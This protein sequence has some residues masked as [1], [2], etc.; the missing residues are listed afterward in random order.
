MKAS[1]DYSFLIPYCSQY[2]LLTDV[3]S[4]HGC[5]RL[6]FAL[7][8]PSMPLLAQSDKALFIDQGGSV[9]IG[10]PATNWFLAL[11]IN[12]RAAAFRLNTIRNYSTDTGYASFIAF[13]MTNDVMMVPNVQM[14][15]LGSVNLGGT[16]SLTRFYIGLNGADYSTA[17]H[18]VM[19]PDGSGGVRVG[20]G[21]MSP[22]Q[23][24]HVNGN[25]LANAYQQPSS[26]RWKTDV[27]P[28][29]GAL[30]LVARL[31]GVRFSWRDT[32]RADIGLIAEEVGAVVP[33]VVTF[34]TDGIN[35]ESVDYARMV[36]VLVEA[37]KEERART[38]A[39]T[40]RVAALEALVQPKGAQIPAGAR[41]AARIE[42]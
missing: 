19:V 25:V 39:L 10:A 6:L 7:L 22:T 31:R 12:R 29:E 11:D 3:L 1:I 23:R 28:I 42:E 41:A 4:F 33:E 24:L 2:L 13:D 35:A 38:E 27:R 8:V 14:G 21:T 34:S 9:G 36:A 20:L 17:T 30:D 18:F 32:G 5:A 16:P 40:Q 15:T 37:L 26:R